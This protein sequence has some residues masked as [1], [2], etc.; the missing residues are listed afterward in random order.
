M[1]YVYRLIAGVGIS[2]VSASMMV[3]SYNLDLFLQASSI[4]NK[5]INVIQF[6]II[7]PTNPRIRLYYVVSLLYK[8]PRSIYNQIED[9]EVGKQVGSRMG[10][11][12]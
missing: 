11:L 2:T 10:H 6:K 9:F 7:H 12:G 8:E 3:K 4:H 1:H 5:A